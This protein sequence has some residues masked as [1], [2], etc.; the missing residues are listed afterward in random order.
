M[1]MLFANAVHAAMWHSSKGAAAAQLSCEVL[2]A[3]GMLGG[4]VLSYPIHY[5]LDIVS[6][7]MVVAAQVK[8]K[9][10]PNLWFQPTIIVRRT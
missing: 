7:M 1:Y 9:L 5:F 2:P 10:F 6:K 8:H 4:S 3:V